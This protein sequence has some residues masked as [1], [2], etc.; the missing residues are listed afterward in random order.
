MDIEEARE[1]INKILS[2]VAT[3]PEEFKATTYELLL[4]HF[5][6][7]K[8]EAPPQTPTGVPTVIIPAEPQ[9]PLDVR[10][11]INQY[12]VDEALLRKAF[13]ISGSEV[14]SS[15]NIRT[16]VKAQ[17]QV[18]VACLIALENA[19][20]GGRFEFSTE[21]VR[22]KLQELKLFDSPNFRKIFKNNEGLFMGLDDEAQVELSASGKE[23]LAET[24]VEITQ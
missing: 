8:R 24:I 2:L 1:T 4:S 23:L 19:L 10:A 18:Q 6:Q 21:S 9:I 7:S 12:G 17:A 3:L 5:L 15:Y 13:L 20:R 22:Q 11:F 16:D 14:R